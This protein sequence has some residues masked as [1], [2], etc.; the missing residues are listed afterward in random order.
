MI[1]PYLYTSLH[2][3]I[4]I[5]IMG[6]NSSIL[7]TLCYSHSYQEFLTLLT[8]PVNEVA[9]KKG[10]KCNYL[11]DYTFLIKGSALLSNFAHIMRI[12]FEYY[13]LV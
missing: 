7:L 13:M 12:I 5:N 8:A 1:K 6:I 10:R 2:S 3:L 11:C 4:S 9:L